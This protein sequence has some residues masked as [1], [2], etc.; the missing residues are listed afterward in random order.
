MGGTP[1]SVW[2]V[3]Q[4]FSTLT[5]QNQTLCSLAFFASIL[6]TERHFLLDQIGATFFGRGFAPVQQES[7]MFTKTNP[8]L[9]LCLKLLIGQ[10][11]CPNI[12]TSTQD[13]MEK[14]SPQC[15]K[16]WVKSGPG[17]RRILL[18]LW[19]PAPGPKIGTFARNY[20]TRRPHFKKYKIFPT[21]VLFL[22]QVTCEQAE[23]WC[24]AVRRVSASFEWIPFSKYLHITVT[25]VEVAFAKVIFAQTVT[26]RKTVELAH[27]SISFQWIYTHFSVSVSAKSVRKLVS[28]LSR[29]Q[30]TLSWGLAVWGLSQTYQCMELNPWEHPNQHQSVPSSD[31][32]ASGQ[33]FPVWSKI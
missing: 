24:S 18:F 14:L 7:L 28:K 10:K 4:K 26:Q 20:S 15:S 6:R 17:W 11:G 29:G 3:H 16:Q 31:W 5:Q 32:K 21:K 12:P 19:P 1:V 30:R 22:I 23:D 27:S 9:I 33:W 8:F 2:S 13:K 25:L